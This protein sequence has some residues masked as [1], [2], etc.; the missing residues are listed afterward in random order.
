MKKNAPF[1]LRSGN[2]PSPAQF[3]KGMKNTGLA[4]NLGSKQFQETGQRKNFK[5]TKLGQSLSKTRKDFKKTQVGKLVTGITGSIFGSKKNPQFIGNK[6]SLGGT[7]KHGVR[8]F[9]AKHLNKP[10]K[11]R[12][13][14]DTATIGEVTITAKGPSTK[15][16]MPK[17]AKYTDAIKIDKSKSF[18]S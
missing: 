14:V 9:A 15:K 6:R 16:P 10:A 18:F 17:G 12:S 7:I 5:D 8:K 1:K 3:F 2:K 13:S 4:K 11:P